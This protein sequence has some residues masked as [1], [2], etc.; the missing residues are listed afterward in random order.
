MMRV[1]RTAPHSFIPDERGDDGLYR[2][3]FSR[4]FLL[5]DDADAAPPIR[6]ANPR[7]L[8]D[9]ALARYQLKRWRH[10]EV[11]DSATGEV[12][13]GPEK[14]ND[15]FGNGLMMC[16][17]DGLPVAA[18]LNFEETLKLHDPRLAEIEKRAEEQGG[19]V[20]PEDEFNYFY[21]RDRAAR[22][23]RASSGIREYNEWNEPV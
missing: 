16:V 11:R 8:H 14:R 7:D 1:D 6:I 4:F 22:S 21:K 10:L 17:W 2:L 9:S 5:V 15:D 13:R 20:R 3:G 18:P 19:G 12:E 23:V